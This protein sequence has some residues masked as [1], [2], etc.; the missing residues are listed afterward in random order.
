MD[1]AD[2]AHAPID[3]AGGPSVAMGIAV[4]NESVVAIVYERNT[5]GAPNATFSVDIQVAFFQLGRRL[6]LVHLQSY[7][8]RKQAR[9]GGTYGGSEYP[10]QADGRDF[11]L[12]YSRVGEGVTDP[13][14]PDAVP[15]RE[16]KVNDD[17]ARSRIVF[18]RIEHVPSPR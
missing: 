17:Y 8:A 7:N 13:D 1:F 15:P 10:I 18:V 14:A 4:N 9:W 11:I 2:D 5:P 16:G 3:L 12:A 6:G